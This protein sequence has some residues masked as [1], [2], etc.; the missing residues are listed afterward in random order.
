MATLTASVKTPIP[1]ATASLQNNPVGANLLPDLDVQQAAVSE[2][3]LSLWQPTK[4][5]MPS[6]SYCDITSLRVALVQH[7]AEIAISVLGE[8]NLRLCSS[9]RELRFGNRGS[10]AIAIN[11]PKA[12]QWYDHETGEGGD[13]IDLIRRE[14]CCS[15]RD[16]TTYAEELIGTAPQRRRR[17]LGPAQKPISSYEESATKRAL[18]LLSEGVPIGDTP[19]AAFLNWRGVLEPAVELGEETL[20]FH[21][22]CPF[23]EGTRHP[24]M[25]ALMR[26]ISSNEP[27]AVQRTALTQALM[28]AISQ[29]T[30]AEFKKA[31]GKVSRMTL[32]PLTGTA[33]KLSCDEDVTLGLAI[34]E[35]TE[36]VLAAMRLGFRPAWALGGTSGVKNFPI[37][38]GIESLTILVDNDA[39]GAGQR[40]AQECSKR[41]IDA[42]REV[43]RAVPNHS[44]DDF[45]DVLG[46]S[47]T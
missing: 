6:T 40:A 12:G 10:L 18:R 31:G 34:G 28:Q 32:G 24:C 30:F 13:L 35:G 22:H 42:G 41:W 20:R 19:A 3:L 8:P 17:S 43:F 29:T 39:S 21:P 7:A 33:I 23:G 46:G 11:G 16:A 44:G 1:P 9:G 25:L 37:L 47:R 2:N 36:T 38:S 15:F 4:A 5:T 14:R 45:N 26:D 27:R